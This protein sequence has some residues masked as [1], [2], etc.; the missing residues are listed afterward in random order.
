[1]AAFDRQ[2]IERSLKSLFSFAAVLQFRDDNVPAQLVLVL[3]P[4]EIGM[5]LHHESDCL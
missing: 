1:V 5:R 2:V 4:F 3:H